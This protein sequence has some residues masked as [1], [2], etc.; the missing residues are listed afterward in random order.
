M[1]EVLAD[2]LGPGS[3]RFTS[4]AK[5]FA[6]PGMLAAGVNHLVHPKVYEPFM[7]D[8]LPAHREL[9]YVSGV[10]QILAGVGSM[11]PG[12]RKRAGLLSI[13]TLVAIYP[14]DL[15]VVQH[16]EKFSKVSAGPRGQRDRDHKAAPSMGHR[17]GCPVHS[18]PR[19]H[20][21]YRPDSDGLLGQGIRN[22]WIAGVPVP[23]GPVAST[24]NV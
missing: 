4:A 19:L 15:W 5:T 17:G 12:T 16:P 7:P 13:A 9:V 14:A 3:H 23:L 22:V 24:E 1:E 10:A 20:L 8:Y 6:G 11:L 18:G 21:T 2:Q